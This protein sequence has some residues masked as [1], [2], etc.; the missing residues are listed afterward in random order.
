MRDASDR[1]NRREI[2]RVARVLRKRANAALA[3]HD[4]VVSFGHHVLGG[5]Q[6]LVERR[7]EPAFQQDGDARFAGASQQGK[8]LHVARADLDDVAVAFDEIDA[9]FVECFSDDLQ[10]VS[11]ADV[12]E[13]F[14]SF[15]AETLE[16]V[17]RRSWLERAATKETSAAA[18]HC[19]GD[20]ERLRATLDRAPAGDDR[21]IVAADGRVADAD[22]GFFGAQ[23]EGD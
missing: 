1:R 20:S 5:E 7:R 22:D 23:I 21:E 6:P 11:F 16:S 18:T 17:R 15:F 8:V 14:E 10:A 2:E 13:Y 19:F 12:G 9:R 3:E 4:L